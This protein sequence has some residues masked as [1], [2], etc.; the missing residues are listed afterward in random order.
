MHFARPSFDSTESPAV[1]INL[2]LTACGRLLRRRS[3]R[4]L[5]VLGPRGSGKTQLLEE[6]GRAAVRLSFLP[7]VIRASDEKTP[8]V[9]LASQ[10]LI[11]LRTLLSNE[12]A[13]S[14]AE[15]GL[16]LLKAFAERHHCE[17]S[18]LDTSDDTPAL[19]AL[20]GIL[21]SDLSDL[22]VVTGEAARAAGADWLLMTDDIDRLSKADLAAL[23]ASLHR[24]N[25]EELPVMFVG[26]GLPI[27]TRRCDEA[28]SYAERLFRFAD[29]TE[30]VGR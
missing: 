26:T 9:L 16:A 11:V 1:L 18:D 13:R 25:Q 4:H 3:A 17:L 5:L 15:E 27:A 10:M 6:I 30:H 24:T 29:I 19:G 7:S 8:I 21:E 23:L 14:K 22:F 2:T 20:S 12:S 28:K